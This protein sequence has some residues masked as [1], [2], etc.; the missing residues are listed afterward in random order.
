MTAYIDIQI[1]MLPRDKFKET[2]A[3]LTAVYWDFHRVQGPNQTFPDLRTIFALALYAGSLFYQV[4]TNLVTFDTM[5]MLSE[6]SITTW[7]LQ[8]KRRKHDGIQ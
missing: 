7:T 1:F 4:K 6:Q 8:S 3:K 5:K 2:N